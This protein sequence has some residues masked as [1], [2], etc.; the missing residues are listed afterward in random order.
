MRMR[1][2]A[3]LGGAVAVVATGTLTGTAAAEPRFGFEQVTDHVIRPGDRAWINPQLATD[4]SGQPEGTFVYAVGG[5]PLTDPAWRAGGAP[6]GMTVDLASFETCKAKPGVAGVFLCP[7]KGLGH[8]PSPLVGAGARAADGATAYYGVVYVP[9]GGDLEQGVK[10]AQTA[11][12]LREDST[13]A[14]RRVTVRTPAEVARNTITLTTPRLKAGAAVTH[15]VALKAVHTGRLSVA[16]VQSAAP[17]TERRMDYEDDRYTID[18]VSAGPDATCVPDWHDGPAVE[19]DVR[20]PGDVN[21]TYRVTSEERLQA[22]HLDVRARYEVWT[23]DEANP[24]R[25]ASFQVD[26]PYRVRDRHQLFGRTPD[27]RL[28][29]H[30][31]TGRADGLVERADLVGPGWNAYDQLTKTAPVT[32][33]G[34]GGRILGRDSAGVLWSY[35]P[36]ETS[37]SLAPRTKVGPGWKAYREITGAGDLTGDRRA[38][39]LARDPAGVLWLYAGTK[40]AKAPFA[41][42]AKVGGG[43]NQYDRLVGAGDLTRD[44]KAD[45]LAV[46]GTGAL[47]L[48]A[49][50]GDAKAPFGGRT[51]IADGTDWRQYRAVAATGDLTDDGRPDLLA[52]DREGVVHLYR[53]TGRADG[54]FGARERAELFRFGGDDGAVRDYTAL[55]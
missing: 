9:S 7:A 29:Q 18:S 46:D 44:G 4:G 10:E 34:T 1:V 20:K 36:T 39:L 24:A 11:G 38:D 49:G 31:G 54:P 48:Y 45:L 47:W 19:C 28:R 14:A 52:Q 30:S 42:R 53:G 12:L 35:A 3:A 37:G 51:R 27:G 6:A 16:L 33:R 32:G 17:A 40:D 5:K 2:L 26:S 55:F 43:W 50:T 21:L 23:S 8:I 15:T 22:W 41:A 13:H 25:T